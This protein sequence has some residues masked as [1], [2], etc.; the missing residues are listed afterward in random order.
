M[1]RND[2][3]R[4]RICECIEKAVPPL[5][6]AT[7][8]RKGGA[9]TYSTS[10]PD[11]E[12]DI[13]VNSNSMKVSIMQKGRESIGVKIA[14]SS[15]QD[16]SLEDIRDMTLLLIQQKSFPLCDLRVPLA[17]HEQSRQMDL[18]EDVS[19]LSGDE[20]DVYTDGGCMIPYDCIGGWAFVIVSAGGQISSSSGSDWATTNNRMEMTAVIKAL[21]M[22]KDMDLSRARI[23]MDSQYVQKG[24]TEWFRGWMLSD[25][26]LKDGLK[27]RDLWE[28]LF[29]LRDGMPFPVE[30]KWIRG[31]NGDRWNELCDSMVTHEM[32]RAVD[33]RFR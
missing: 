30:Y 22:L 26:R 25:G 29:A 15:I 31:H 24:L 8:H 12:V 21:E 13:L 14:L 11:A 18:F 27:N 3:I 4:K 17:R 23:H 19:P 6:L 9:V 7:Q 1:K 5:F 10:L 2:E 32:D 16:V 28:R 33:E 20:V